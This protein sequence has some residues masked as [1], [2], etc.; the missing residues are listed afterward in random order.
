MTKS[1]L[2]P[3]A[4][5]T[6]VSC[7]RQFYKFNENDILTN[8]HVNEIISVTKDNDLKLYKTMDDIPEI[9]TKTI[10]S[11]GDK[12]FIVDSTYSY[13][14]ADFIKWGPKR[15]LISIFKNKDYFIMTYEHTGRGRH[16]HIMYFQ[17]LDKKIKEFWVGF[18]NVTGYNMDNVQGIRSWLET[19]ASDLQTNIVSY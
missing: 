17:F 3:L 15:E 5:L 12:F 1:V 10:N 7:G 4:L 9:V 11:W 2:L 8:K 13:Q 19:R 6:L 16:T 18:G 14:P